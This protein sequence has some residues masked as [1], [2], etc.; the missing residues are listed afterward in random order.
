MAVGFSQSTTNQAQFE[1]SRPTLNAT[2]NRPGADEYPLWPVRLSRRKLT[3][4]DRPKSMRTR[5]TDK[6]SD[7]MHRSQCPP[8][9]ICKFSAAHRNLRSALKSS[10]KTL[11][12][13]PHASSVVNLRRRHSREWYARSN[14]GLKIGPHAFKSG[15]V[16]RNRA[17]AHEFPFENVLPV[18]PVHDLVRRSTWLSGWSDE[19]S[20]SSRTAS[21]LPRAMTRAPSASSKSVPGFSLPR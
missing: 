16:G 10:N 4:R 13:R 5:R 7:V 8:A 2:E 19:A 12:Q 21:I 11:F 3:S 6:P 17:A 20:S 15:N 1:P 14:S 18:A 9:S